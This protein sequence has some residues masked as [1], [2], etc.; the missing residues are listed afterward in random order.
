MRTAL[1]YILAARS[2]NSKKGQEKIYGKEDNKG[3]RGISGISEISDPF[4]ER[5]VR[6]QRGNCW[7]NSP[8]TAAWVLLRL[9]AADKTLAKKIYRETF[10]S[11]VTLPR[12]YKQCEEATKGKPE[13]LESLKEFVRREFPGRFRKLALK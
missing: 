8:R 7:Y 11:R 2:M 1:R 13:D 4:I 9:L 3:L 5:Q 6:Q 12:A 10:S